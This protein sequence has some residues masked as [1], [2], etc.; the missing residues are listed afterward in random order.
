[1][2][3][4]L[5]ANMALSVMRRWMNEGNRQYKE[6]TR[7]QEA[8]KKGLDVALPIDKDIMFK[9]LADKVFETLTSSSR[10]VFRLI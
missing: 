7:F 10:C 2:E 4:E 9:A 1:M 6:D 5:E 8:L 3:I